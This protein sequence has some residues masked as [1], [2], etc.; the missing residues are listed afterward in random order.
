MINCS[1]NCIARRNLTVISQSLIGSILLLATELWLTLSPVALCGGRKWLG[2]RIHFW[3]HVFVTKI[4]RYFRIW[5]FLKLKLFITLTKENIHK[6]LE[7][8][9]TMHLIYMK[10][11]F[12][13]KKNHIFVF[14]SNDQFFGKR[15]KDL[16]GHLKR[17]LIFLVF[18]IPYNL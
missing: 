1:I 7:F 18:I 13:K 12:Y 5:N 4:E 8:K 17:W 10:A 11:W 3:L 15:R 14:M 9:D 6:W 2:G 16:K